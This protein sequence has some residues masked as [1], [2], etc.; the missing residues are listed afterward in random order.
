M[1][2]Y[3]SWFDSEHTIIIYEYY[4]K[5]TW[6]ELYT[7]SAVAQ[8]LATDASGTV[9][10]FSVRRDDVA[11]SHIPS[12][13][14][15]HFAVLTQQLAPKIALH[16]SVPGGHETFWKNLSQSIRAMYPRFAQHMLVAD[17]QEEALQMIKEQKAQDAVAGS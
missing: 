5:W 3:A 11:R 7:A 14:I 17:T 2:V 15:T 12:N 10:S 13:I 8:E 6:D 4:G 16:I 9:Y 1:A